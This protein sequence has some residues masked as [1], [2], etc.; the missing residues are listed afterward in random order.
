[1]VVEIKYSKDNKVE[2]MLKE[3]MGQIR[4]NKYYEK[5]ESKEDV[6]LLGVV[7]S[8]NK[9]IGCKFENILV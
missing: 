1:V 8:E 2:E 5:Y 7:F 4:N 6:P 9:E 3:A